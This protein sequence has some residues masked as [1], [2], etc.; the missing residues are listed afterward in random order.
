MKPLLAVL[1]LPLLLSS[2]HAADLLTSWQAARTYDANFAAATN[3]LRAGQEKTRQGDATV[4]PQLAF[5][6]TATRI[7]TD[8]QS[9]SPGNTMTDTVTQGPQ[10]NAGL[11]LAQPIY[12]AA[13]FAMRDQL[14]KQAMQAQ[15]QY[16]LA[17]QDLIL[18]V[19]K[20]YF[21]VL[22]AQD[23][24]KLVDAQKEAVSQQLGLAKKSFSVGLSTIT[25]T[26]EA[27]ARYDAILAAEIA[28]RSDLE[29]KSDSYRQL[30]GLDP[31]TLAPVSDARAPAL[32]QPAGLSY[33][34]AQADA[35]NLNV[36]AQHL[37][38]EIAA[39]DIDR[40][41][42][43]TA[44]SLFLVAS[45]G[46]KWDGSGAS[47]SGPL[48]RTTNSAIGLQLAIPLYTGG[49]RSSQYRQAVALADQ[50]RDLL[51]ATRRD[52]EQSTRQSF[53][54]VESGVAQIRA[55]EQARISSESSLASTK[56]GREVGVR[57]TI[58]VLNA[59]QN[60]FQTLFNLVAARHQY[61]LNRLQLAASVGKL[62][63]SELADVNDWLAVNT[64]QNN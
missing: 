19:A 46:G 28:A 41:R 4:L 64:L 30:T 44:P 14:K 29:I 45:Y 9:T 32:P 31:A 8:S 22:V 26:H 36:Q 5:S 63:Q 12:N 16:R 33:W 20:A 49:N 42:L 60:Y 11:S 55:L 40:Y 52:A 34:L 35:G 25:D 37:G 27:Q 21:D 6:G 17:E 1:S 53:L 57:T 51:Q 58:D 56:M 24:L 50:Q 15:V 54:G 59:Q 3:A 39:R 48:D 43:E 7:R 38:V 61:L 62:N 13:A 2:A 10:Y 23:S 47:R 18:R